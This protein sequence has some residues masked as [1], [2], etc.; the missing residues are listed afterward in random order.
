MYCAPNKYCEFA[1]YTWFVK[2]QIKNKS[3]YF[4]WKHV[5]QNVRYVDVYDA[6]DKKFNPPKAIYVLCRESSKP[7]VTSP[8]INTLIQDLTERAARKLIRSLS[9]PDLTAISSQSVRL[10]RRPFIRVHRGSRQLHYPPWLQYS[11]AS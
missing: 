11:S 7:R 8:R 9:T 1:I 3:F 10:N 2:Y 4:F 5:A 6:I